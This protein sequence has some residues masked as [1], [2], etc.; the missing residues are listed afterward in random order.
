MDGSI[1]FARWCQCAPASNTYFLRPT[2]VHNWNGILIGSVIFAQLTAEGPYTLQWAAPF[3]LKTVL[4]HGGYGPTCNTCFLRPIHSACKQHLDRFSHFC[5][6]HDRDWLT[7]HTTR[8]VTTGRIY[9]ITNSG[10]IKCNQCRTYNVCT[11]TASLVYTRFTQ[12]IR[13]KEQKHK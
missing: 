13:E 4:T 7:D 5:R 8:S 6:V 12:E 9:G 10:S 1:V 11:E 3:S 2:W